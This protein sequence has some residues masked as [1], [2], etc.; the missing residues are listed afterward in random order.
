VVPFEQ[1]TGA[2]DATRTPDITAYPVL[3]PDGRRS[4]SLRLVDGQ[5][6]ELAGSQRQL[7]VVTRVPWWQLVLPV[8]VPLGVGLSV[9]LWRRDQIQYAR[10]LPAEQRQR[11]V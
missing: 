5:G 7:A 2:V 8:L 10:S 1:P 6:R 4:L 11:L 3:A 9:V